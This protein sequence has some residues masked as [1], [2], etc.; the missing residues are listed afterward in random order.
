MNA[1][2]P[3]PTVCDRERERRLLDKCKRALD[4]CDEQPTQ[5]GT[6]CFVPCGGFLELR[7]CNKAKYCVNTHPPIRA[8]AEALTSAQEITASGLAS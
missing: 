2:T 4:L 3:Q 6:L 1:G 5:S 8:R 7:L